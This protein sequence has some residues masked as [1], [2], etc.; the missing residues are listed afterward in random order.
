M[1]EALAFDHFEPP[2]PSGSMMKLMTSAVGPVAQQPLILFRRNANE[3]DRAQERWNFQNAPGASA[4]SN[5]F[6]GLEFRCTAW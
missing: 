3:F 1:A 4:R 6:G 5:A 2:R